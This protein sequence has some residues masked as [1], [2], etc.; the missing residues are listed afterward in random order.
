MAG[1]FRKIID[2]ND[3]KAREQERSLKRAK[4]QS[5]SKLQENQIFFFQKSNLVL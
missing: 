1:I 4:K 2:L 3:F 5:H